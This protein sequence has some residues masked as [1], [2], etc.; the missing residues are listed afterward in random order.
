M[1]PVSINKVGEGSILGK[2]IYSSDGRLLLGKGVGLDSKIIN[3]L[4]KHQI[5]YVYIDDEISEGIEIEGVVDDAVKIEAI[6]SIRRI[7]MRAMYKCRGKE[8][9]EWIPLKAQLEVEEIIESLINN[10]KEKENLI[11]SMIQLLGTDAYIYEHS[12]NVAILSIITAKAIGLSKEE[13]RDIAMGALLHDIGMAKIDSD[14]LFKF[15]KLSNREKEIMKKHTE[16]G[17][18][19]VR[20]DLSISYITKQIIYSHHELL[21]GSGYPRGL[22]GQEILETT[23]ITTICNMFDIMTNDRGNNTKI[24]IYKALEVLSSMAIKKIDL[25]IFSKFAENIA[26]YPIG[27]GVLLEDGR[28]GI[29]VDVHRSCPTRPI[30]RIFESDDFKNCYELDLMKKLNV[31]I[32]DTIEL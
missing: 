21:D 25:R 6:T 24:P 29:V 20:D 8:K 14:I 19:M 31:F 23:M 12:V 10:L 9:I 5:L 2:S 7:F 15:N 13:I 26:V 30:I 16:Y 3:I 1:R 11:Y 17:Y 4:K 28:K 27:T 22:S 18:D 32:K